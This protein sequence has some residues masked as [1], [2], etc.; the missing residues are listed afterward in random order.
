VLPSHREGFSRSAMEAAA[1]G[2]A[3]VLS[4]I[5]GCREIGQDGRHLLLV[6]P[7][8]PARLAQA[9]LGLGSDPDLRQR[10]GEA[11]HQRAVT[12]FDQR[13]VA[14]TSIETYAAV[15]RRRQLEWEE[16]GVT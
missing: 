9:L 7:R 15:A 3:M 14:R 12:H 6:P 5:R 10:L 1:C 2:T 16:G 11:A 13:A 4:D 8:D